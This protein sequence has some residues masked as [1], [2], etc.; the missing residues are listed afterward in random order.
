MAAVSV[1][2]DRGVNVNCPATV[3]NIGESMSC[4]ASGSAQAGQYSNTGTVSALPPVGPAVTASDI[5]HYFGL[6]PTNTATA[7]RTSTATITPKVTGTPPT[8]TATGTITPNP[9]LTVSVSPLT[10]RVNQ[11]LTFTIRVSNPG[12]APAY[13]S[14]LHDSFPSF[15]DVINV[16]FDEGSV[17]KT[18]HSVTVDLDD[19][20]PGATATIAILTRVNSSLTTSQTLSNIVT[21]SYNTNLVRSASVVYGVIATS[22][23]PGTGDLPLTARSTAGT[24]Q[25]AS[26]LAIFS[27]LL[28]GMIGGLSLKNQNGK[29]LVPVIGLLL[30]GIMIAAAAC[31]TTE[32]PQKQVLVSPLPS[33]T[34]TQTLLPFMPA[35]RFSTPEVYPTMPSYP[36]PSPSLVPTSLVD[37][38]DVD[39]SAVTRVVIP[40]LDVDALVHYIP[41]EGLSWPIEGLREDIAWLGN[42]SWPGLGGNTVLAGHVTVKGVGDGPF[43]YLEDLKEG[44]EVLVYTE[45]NTYT[46]VVREQ[47]TVEETDL[48]VTLPTINPQ[49]TLITCTGWDNELSIYR[50]RRVVFADLTSSR[51]VVYQGYSR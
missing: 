34:S 42:S 29:G 45:K 43:R 40:A 27:L 23:L 19:L 37:G 9:I 1:S 21:L 5:S 15:I 32:Q 38:Q 17:T 26:R 10:A 16:T 3:L 31:S 35:Y 6:S 49:L 51:E 7:T 41:F 14:I 25:V 13:N 24:A 44:D 22:T 33:E 12:T 18:T 48:G 4:T 47:V 39:S 2:D 20:A 11:S 28:G 36:V 8:P 30:L 46:Y 50:F